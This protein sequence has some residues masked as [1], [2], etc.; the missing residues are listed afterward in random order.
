MATQKKPYVIA[1][2]EHYWDRELA[3]KWCVVIQV[4]P[5]PV[6][7]PDAV[8]QKRNR[9]PASGRHSACPPPAGPASSA[10]S[11][12][13]SERNLPRCLERTC[14]RRPADPADAGQQA[15][16]LG[17][18]AMGPLPR[19]RHVGTPRLGR[20]PVRGGGTNLGFPVEPA[21]GPPGRLL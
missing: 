3:A 15:L 1:I 12:G 10:V 7:V 9:C 2:E 5:G 14:A 13:R 20:G 21:G 17:G 6:W 19:R 16:A 8:F 11:M 4:V 18:G